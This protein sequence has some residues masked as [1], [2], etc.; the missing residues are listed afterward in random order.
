[1]TKLNLPELAVYQLLL[2]DNVQDFSWE[3]LMCLATLQERM[4]QTFVAGNT[5]IAVSDRFQKREWHGGDAAAAFLA[6]KR[7][8]LLGMPG[9]ILGQLVQAWRKGV[10]RQEALGAAV[11]AILCAIAEDGVD[12]GDFLL[13][14]SVVESPG[15]C[16]DP[17]RLPAGVRSLCE[18]PGWREYLPGDLRDAD[19]YEERLRKG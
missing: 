2:A 5:N 17:A 10:L 14:G 16:Q 11:P 6:G 12:P 7:E 1:M 18:A 3:D 15:V 13:P 8:E 9:S 4:E 19:A